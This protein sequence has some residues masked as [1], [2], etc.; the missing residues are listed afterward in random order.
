MMIGEE[1]GINGGDGMASRSSKQVDNQKSRLSRGL[2]D[3]D[4]DVVSTCRLVDAK[5]KGVPTEEGESGCFG[6][7]VKGFMEEATSLGNVK[8]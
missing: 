6:C 4:D 8:K 5:V 7:I 1:G 3:V 2:G